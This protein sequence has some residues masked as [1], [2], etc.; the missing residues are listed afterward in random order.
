M[1]SKGCVLSPQLTYGDAEVNAYQKYAS[2]FSLACSDVSPVTEYVALSACSVTIFH[3]HR[4]HHPR[5]ACA[6]PF[7]AVS[8]VEIEESLRA[9]RWNT[10]RV[11]SAVYSLA[12]EGV[13]WA[14]VYGCVGSSGVGSQILATDPFWNL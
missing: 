1:V 3:A 14:F 10:S 11:S 12:S 8:S 13:Q 9:I 7:G 6:Q 5:S 2:V 4:I